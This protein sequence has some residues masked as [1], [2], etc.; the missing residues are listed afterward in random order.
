MDILLELFAIWTTH[1]RSTSLT[2]H[3]TPL[4]TTLVCI[5]TIQKNLNLMYTKM[6]C[7]D[8]HWLHQLMLASDLYLVSLIFFSLY[9]Y[10]YNVVQHTI[11]IKIAFEMCELWLLLYRTHTFTILQISAHDCMLVIF[12]KIEITWYKLI[13]K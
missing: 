1:S 11:I 8:N 10:F 13:T 12:S 5:K 7:N 2:T 9:V 4:N 3:V 6:W